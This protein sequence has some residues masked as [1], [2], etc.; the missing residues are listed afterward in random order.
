MRGDSGERRRWRGVGTG[1][2][3]GE[4]RC[5]VGGGGGE[6]CHAGVFAVRRWRSGGFEAGGT[7]Q[8]GRHLC[9]RSG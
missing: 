7:V 2:G 6:V 8:A 9:A 1:E 4:R 5:K 3:G